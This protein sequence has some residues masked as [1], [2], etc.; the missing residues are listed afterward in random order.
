MPT[1][2]LTRRA[3]LEALA[4]LA[5]LAPLPAPAAPTT[6]DLSLTDPTRQRSL[7]LKLRLPAGPAPWPLVLHSH[8]L[9]GSRDGGAVWGAAWAAAGVAVLHL[10]HPGS[11]TAALADLRQAAS[12]AQLLARVRDAQFVLDELAR[13]HAA[14]EAPWA[15]LR[16]DAVGFSGHSFGAI[17]TQALAGQRW[18][19]GAS[20]DEPRLKAFVALSPSPRN[21]SAAADALS[22]ITR[23]FFALTGSHDGDPFGSFQ[24]GEARAQVYAA[25]PPGRKALLWLDGADHMTFGGGTPR[26]LPNLGPWRRAPQAAEREPAHQA[27]VARLTAAWWRWRLLGDA[28]AEAALRQPAGLGPGDRFERS[29]G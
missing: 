24:G 16:L 7:P 17:T 22:G 23:P 2:P 4:S 11:D 20:V 27:L 18:P 15:Q 26:R 3:A 9:G 19:G 13:R 8:G 25:L 14:G 21:G 28:D 29:D 12:G 6:T 1:R 10:Q 5:A